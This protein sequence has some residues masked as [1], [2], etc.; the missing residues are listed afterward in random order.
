MTGAQRIL[1]LGLL[2]CACRSDPA[3]APAPA[4]APS[5]LPAR[6]V[7]EAPSPEPVDVAPSETPPEPAEEPAA[8]QPSVEGA[9]IERAIEPLEGAATPV[10]TVARGRRTFA[11]FRWDGAAVEGE[12]IAGEPGGEARLEAIEEALLPCDS[13]DDYSR[14]DCVVHAVSEPYLAMAQLGSGHAWGVAVIERRGGVFVRV[15]RRFLSAWSEDEGEVL[16]RTAALRVRD[17]DGDGAEELIVTLPIVPLRSDLGMGGGDR[18]VVAYVLDAGSLRTQ[19]RAT[20][21]YESTTMDVAGTASTCRG[22]WRLTDVNH[23]GHDDITV[24]ARCSEA[25]QDE[26][27][28]DSSARRRSD[29]RDCLYDAASDAWPCGEPPIAD[30]YFTGAG[31]GAIVA[32]RPEDLR[33]ALGMD[34]GA[35]RD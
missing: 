28:G 17:V 3:P 19:F 29:R 11:L 31:S 26:V 12:R 25:W 4:P 34:R 13:A 18:A 32:E 7:V 22:G 20:S 2:V 9:T 24:N 15:A 14:F 1:S 10:S 8:A 30:W 6:A 21:E 16:G 23:D 35:P 33:A 5:P 27:S